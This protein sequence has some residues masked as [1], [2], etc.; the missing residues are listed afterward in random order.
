MNHARDAMSTRPV[1]TS[2]VALI[3]AM[4]LLFT[5]VAS[6]SPLRTKPAAR[7]GSNPG[8]SRASQTG[9]PATPFISGQVSAHS[10]K[11]WVGSTA[12]VLHGKKGVVETME[13]IDVSS[14]N[15]TNRFVEYK[16]GGHGSD[17]FQP[18]PELPEEI[19][20]WSK[21]LLTFTVPQPPDWVRKV[22][23][24]GRKVN[25]VIF[26]WDKFNVMLARKGLPSLEKNSSDSSSDSIK[27]SN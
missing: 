8:Q 27:P 21:S 13:W 17:M 12:I 1:R 3:A 2:L 25:R 24:V 23:L 19:V 11:F 15:P 22:P 9:T 20:A 10:G 26:C 14:G 18:H 16:T 5:G 6:G 4:S 7:H